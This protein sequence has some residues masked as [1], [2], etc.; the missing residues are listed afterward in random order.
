LQEKAMLQ[1][2]IKSAPSILCFSL[3][4]FREIITENNDLTDSYQAIKRDHEDSAKEYNQMKV[5]LND[6]KLMCEAALVSPIPLYIKL[7]LAETKERNF[8]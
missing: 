8:D 6:N 4:L 5:D 7:I 2:R 1:N 3:T